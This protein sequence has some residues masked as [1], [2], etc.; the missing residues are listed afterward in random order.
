[1]LGILAGI[2]VGVPL[3]LGFGYFW[4]HT[5]AAILG[6]SRGQANV[7]SELPLVSD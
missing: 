1:M 3:G 7:N 4:G 2:V 6:I 5:M